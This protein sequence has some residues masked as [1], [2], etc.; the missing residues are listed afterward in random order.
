LT[1]FT[2]KLLVTTAAA[3]S[4]AGVLAAPA[5]AVEPTRETV[6]LHRVLNPFFSCP[7]FAVIGVFDITR[8]VTTFYDQDGTPVMRILHNSI[9]GT[10]TNAV[11]GYSLPSDGVRI[12]HY[13]LVTGELFTTGDNGVTK[14]PDGGAALPGA[15]RLVFDA[16]GHLIE[17]L[18]PDSAEETAQL[19]EAL[20]A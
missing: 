1:P 20:A 16:Q 6:T 18:G 17:H 11:T 14:L 12:F 8:E 7:G 10:V 2:R 5:A 9:T 4:V 15:G 19:C 3:I 13:D